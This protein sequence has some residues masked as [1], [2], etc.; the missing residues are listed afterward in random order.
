MPTGPDCSRR[1]F[2]GA[3][4]LICLCVL[5]LMCLCVFSCERVEL[6]RVARM[7]AARCGTTRRLSPVIPRCAICALGNDGRERCD[8]TT[9]PANQFR[10]S[11]IVSSLRIKNISVYQNENQ[12]HIFAHP[13]PLRGRRP[14]SRTLDGLRWTLMSRRRNATKAYGKTVWSW[15]PLQ[16]SSRW[17]GAS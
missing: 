4:I 10:F 12:V 16:V 7:S 15:R 9:R 11:E 1:I 5:N 17:L 13:V 2:A 14:S 6:Q 8:K 3:C